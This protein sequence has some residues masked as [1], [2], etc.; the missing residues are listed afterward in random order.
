[1]SPAKKKSKPRTVVKNAELRTE[2]VAAERWA[3]SAEQTARTAKAEFKKS[4]KAH[5]RAKKTAKEA[6]K[7]V[8]A[9]R[10]AL[11]EAVKAAVPA[12]KKAAPRGPTRVG[13]SRNRAGGK[14]AA[15]VRDEPAAADV[16]P[17][18]EGGVSSPE[19]TDEALPSGGSTVP[20]PGPSST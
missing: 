2:L 3:E 1:M 11:A 17:P 19:V 15:P 5:R 12:K 13:L 14:K 18:S 7:E 8:K 10:A 9:L 4:R 6:W 20:P 16:V